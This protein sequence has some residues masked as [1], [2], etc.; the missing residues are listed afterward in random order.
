MVLLTELVLL[1]LHLILHVD[2]I[3]LK[4]LV[5][6]VLL[7]NVLLVLHL[8]LNLLLL[9]HWL[10]NLLLILLVL[11]HLVVAVLLVHYAIVLLRM[12]FLLWLLFQSVIH[13]IILVLLL[14]SDGLITIDFIK[15]LFDLLRLDGEILLRASIV[16]SLT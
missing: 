1:V 15:F 14:A 13:N 7:L 3:S 9:L 4:H 5:L 16:L 2:L 12:I 8:L 11:P 10:L 6:V